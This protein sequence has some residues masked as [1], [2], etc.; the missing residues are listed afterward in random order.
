MARNAILFWLTILVAVVA[1]IYFRGY[2]DK[3]KV[4]SAVHKDWANCVQPTVDGGYV[5]TGVIWGMGGMQSA[6][7]MVKTD[8]HGCKL[9][10]KTF[11]KGDV[12]RGN[13]VQQTLDMGYIVAGT[14]WLKDKRHSDIYLLKTDPDGNEIWSKSYGGDGSDEGRSVCQTTDGGYIVAGITDALGDGNK[15]VYLLKTDPDG[16]EV[17]SKSYGGDGSDEGR[18]VCQATDGGYVIAGLTDSFGDRNEE[19]YLLKTD[20]EG[21]LVWGKTFGGEGRDRGESV[22][23]TSDGGY[24][25]VGTTWP[26]D[27]TYSDVYLLKTDLDGRELWHKT[28]GQQYGDHGYSVAQTDGGGYIVVGNTWPIGRMGQS[29]L[30]LLRTDDK[31]GTVWVKTF[32]G[33][34]SVYGHSVCQTTDGGYVAAGKIEDVDEGDDEIYLIKT[35]D[36][37]RLAWRMTGTCP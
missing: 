28:F 1:G 5:I 32:G 25:L 9:W 6:V 19:V 35:Y 22:R 17:W 4:P 14:V 26:G 8:A 13:S 29:S 18:S 23:L 11:G 12:N 21:N 3:A 33:K 37:G 2:K 31:G 16:N 36:N 30:Y 27:A 10:C 24:I 34:G 20:A 7:V 15:D